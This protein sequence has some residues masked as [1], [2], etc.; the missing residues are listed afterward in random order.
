MSDLDTHISEERMRSDCKWK[1]LYLSLIV[2][3]PLILFFKYARTLYELTLS[4]T[5]LESSTGVN[6]LSTL[7]K[8]PSHG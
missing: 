6:N 4:N 5:G 1:T 2:F 3:I 8:L 7:L